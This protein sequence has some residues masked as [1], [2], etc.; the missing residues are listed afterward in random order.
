MSIFEYDKEEEERKL[1]K[2]EFEAGVVKGKME[3][4]ISLQS[5]GLPVEKIAQAV[6]VDEK[7]VQEWLK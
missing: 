2:A 7:L 3:T 4:A 6:N 5:M 1:K